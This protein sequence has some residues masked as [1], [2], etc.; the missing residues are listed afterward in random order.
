MGFRVL[1]TLTPDNAGKYI[2]S[3]RLRPGGLS[4]AGINPD[5][6]RH[7]FCEE[8]AL[9]RKKTYIQALKDAFFLHPFFAYTY[10]QLF[11]LCV[12]RQ[13]TLIPANV[14]VDEQ[15]EALMSFAFSSPGRKTLCEP[16]KDSDVHVIFGMQPEVYE[17]CSRSLLHPHYVHAVTRQLAFWRTQSLVRLPKQLYISLNEGIMYAACF[18]KGILLFINSFNYEDVSEILY[19]TLYIWKQVGMAQLDDELYVAANPEMYEKLAF[20]LRVYLSHVHAASELWPDAPAGTP[21]D[22]IALFACES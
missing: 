22:V 15:K 13:Y 6:K 8:I 16:I 3:I 14:F 7:F 5:E 2:M 21:S 4:F 17:F 12:N 9:D 20:E 10:K 1:D 11:V 18:D 19:Y